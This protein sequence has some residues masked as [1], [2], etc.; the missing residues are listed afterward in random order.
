MTT[1]EL[2]IINEVVEITIKSSDDMVK[3]TE[4]LSRLNKYND[5]L[6]EEE[7]KVVSPIKIALKAAQERFAPVK[8]AYKGAIEALREKMGEYHDRELK[9]RQ[10]AE[11][12]LAGRI[13]EGKG[14]L[15]LETAVKK[16]EELEAVEN[17]VEAD[18]G[19][20]SFMTIED[21]EVMDIT[22]LPTTH[23]LANEVK[24]RASMKAGEKLPGVRYF[25]RSIPRNSR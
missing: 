9:A 22:T 18:T 5:G 13:G 23:I 1:K 14:K 10:E 21:F 15:K 7:N 6:I 3:A 24:I 19:S 20:V 11:K 17:K 8:K 16:M 12:K 2:T 25:T 4:L